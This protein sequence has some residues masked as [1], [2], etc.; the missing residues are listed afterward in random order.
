MSLT[1]FRIPSTDATCRRIR[2]RQWLI[3]AGLNDCQIGRSVGL[4]RGTVRDWRHRRRRGLGW[5]SPDLDCPKCS[6]G[7]PDP[8]T[9]AY[10]RG[11]VFKLR[12]VCA[13]RYPA[14]MDE[15]EEA[16]H[17]MRASRRAAVFRTRKE[18]C[19]ELAA[20]W[21]HWPCLFPQH[22]PGRKHQRK[23]EL[24]PWQQEIAR[25]QPGRLLRGLIHS[26]GCRSLNRVSGYAYTRYQFS[27]RSIDIQEIFCRA[28]DDFGVRWRQMNRY[29]IS[30]ARRPDVAKLDLIVGPKS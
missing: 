13:E 30:V 3:D 4:P 9:Y 29:T 18:G 7:R 19:V 11:A 20:C 12:I 27:N 8:E 24:V 2:G 10:L 22:G 25:R 26:D 6:S 5:R 17:C 21:K 16:I 14:I 23:I 1:D 15:C 28:C